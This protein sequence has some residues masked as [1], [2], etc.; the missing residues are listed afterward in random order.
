[1]Q[2]TPQKQSRPRRVVKKTGDSPVCPR[3]IPSFSLGYTPNS[4]VYTG[5]D[6]VTGN[7]TYSYDDFGRLSTSGK[8]GQGF[9]YKYDRL[10]NR[11]QQNVT[12]GS[13]PSPQHSF[14]A[15][16]HIQ[17]APQNCT[18]AN[19]YCY[20][21]AGNLL[22]DGFHSYT[23]D[24]E[25]RL[26]LVDGGMTASYV[27]DAEGHVVRR[28][29]GTTTLDFVLNL[30][31]KPITELVAG[32]WDR[33]ELYAAGTHVATYA[34]GITY[35]FHPDWLGSV[36]AE[37]KYDGTVA[38]NM[39]NL[40]FGDGQVWTGRLPSWQNFAQGD[41]D[42]ASGLDLFTFRQYS[43]TQGRWTVPDPAGMAA[44]NPADPQTWNRYAYVGN[45]P[46]NA[47]D[48]LGL[49]GDCV[50][51]DPFCG[52]G[53]CDPFF[54][55]PECPLCN[56]DPIFCIGPPDPGSGGGGGGGGGAGP[57]ETP[58]APP[59]RTGGVYANNETLGLP[60]G[61]NFPALSLGNLL[62]LNPN[63][64][65]DFGVCTPVGSSLQTTTMPVPWIWTIPKWVARVPGIFSILSLTLGMTGDGSPKPRDDARE[66]KCADIF[67][68]DIAQC[69][70]LD[71]ASARNRCFDSAH[72]RYGECLTT[73]AP[74][75]PLIKW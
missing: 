15:N 12:A 42:T 24:A 59:Q 56:Y 51:G 43:S 50:E 48:A 60:P 11:V 33:S 67:D 14:D 25:N 66:V 21:A 62:G 37:T 55:V 13:G 68:S 65:C 45:R 54:D 34:D 23:Y 17:G 35:F 9:N 38:G 6:S 1:M 16:N 64:P 75:S 10:S 69:N 18:S 2:L 63:G 30:G 73:G 31:G 39:S 27:Y 32:T 29:L 49:G 74:K 41:I 36:R 52:G 57:P 47:T 58:P 19:A 28:S 44:V 22:N 70:G 20:D 5:N 71:K 4:N 26:T 7:W 53:G 8:S 61:I 72:T 46:L 3:F 40:G